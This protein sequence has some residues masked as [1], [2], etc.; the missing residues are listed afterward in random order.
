MNP[1]FYQNCIVVER[2]LPSVVSS[3]MWWRCWSA[4]VVAVAVIIWTEEIVLA[5][6]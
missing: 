1:M 2:G 4:V 6:T 5:E 3:V